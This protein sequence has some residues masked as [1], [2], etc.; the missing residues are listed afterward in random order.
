MKFLRK[1]AVYLSVAGALL[2]LKDQP[3]FSVNVKEET[4]PGDFKIY[5]IKIS[6]S[7]RKIYVGGRC[8]LYLLTESGAEALAIPAGIKEIRSILATKNKIFLVSEKGLFMR[9]LNNPDA[10]WQERYEVVNAQGI[11]NFEY[12]KDQIVAWNNR[13][14]YMLDPDQAVKLKVMTGEE[15]IVKVRTEG[16]N[17]CLLTGKGCMVMNKNQKSWKR[18]LTIDKGDDGAEGIVSSYEDPEGYAEQTYQGYEPDIDCNR[19]R[20]FISTLSGL[21]IYDMKAEKLEGLNS[22]GLPLSDIRHIAA[23]DDTVIVATSKDLYHMKRRDTFIQKIFTGKDREDLS[24]LCIE[25]VDNENMF[26]W[27]GGGNRLF[28]QQI[29]DG[30][31]GKNKF[32]LNNRETV[33]INEV[34]GMAIE[35]AEVGPEKIKQWRKFAKIK[36]ILPKLSLGLSESN[37]ENIEIYKSATQYY[38][39]NGPREVNRDWSIDLSWDLSDLIWNDAQTS[40]DVRSKLM[41]QMRNDILEEVTR[42]YFERMRLIREIQMHLGEAGIQEKELRVMEITAYIDAYTGGKFSEKFFAEQN[43]KLSISKTNSQI[44]Q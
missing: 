17:M 2:L 39:V 16:D 18:I 35:Y 12:E 20:V 34:Q 11:D 44:S 22:A 15:D 3:G 21:Y 31:S 29:S 26:L 33:S 40:I 10:V 23:M 8:G 1:F 5:S 24:V 41:V 30:I 43:K 25:P 37:D 7:P 9:D 32:Y 38:V 28:K 13:T 19:D 36:A 4:F 6:G 42:L 27:T 14:I